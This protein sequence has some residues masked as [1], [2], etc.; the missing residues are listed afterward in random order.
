VL[1][2]KYRS[3][4][5]LA[6]IVAAFPARA[7]FFAGVSYTNLGF[8]LSYDDG[9]SLFT[10]NPVRVNVGWRGDI[11]GLEVDFYTSQDKTQAAW[12]G[13]DYNFKTGNGGGAYLYLHQKWVYAK[14]GGTWWDTTLTNQSTS[15]SQN[16]TLAQ[17]T[18]VIGLEYEIAKHFYINADYTYAVGSTGYGFARPGAG[19]ADVTTQGGS[20]GVTLGF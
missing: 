6:L 1:F 4:L 11:A 3:V 8:N 14:I 2:N 16:S 13:V 19:D 15:G 18:A 7:E 9:D 17:T 10:T 5:I 12:G 20:I